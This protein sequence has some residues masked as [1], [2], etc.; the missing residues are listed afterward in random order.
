MGILEDLGEIDR[1]LAE[2]EHEAATVFGD[3]EGSDTPDISR[4]R[5]RR[6]EPER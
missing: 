6:A 4:R 3:E 5:E 1:I 2:D